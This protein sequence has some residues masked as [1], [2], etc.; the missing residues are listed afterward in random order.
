MS[1][2]LREHAPI[3]EAGWAL[4]DDEA[5]ERLDARARRPQ[6]RR[7]RRPARLGA[8]G[9]E[10]RSHADSRRQRPPTASTAAQR[11]VLPLVELRAPFTVARAELRDADRGA[12]DVDLDALDEAAHRIAVAENARRLPRLGSGRRS[13]ASLEASSQRGDHARRRLRALSRATSPRRSRRCSRPAS[14][15]PTGWRSGPTPTPACS[16]PASTAA[17]RCS[18]TCA[19]SSAGRSSGRPAST[20]PSCSACAAATS[21]SSPARTSRSATTDHDAD[22]V[23]LYLR[24]ELQLP[25]R[26]ARGRRRASLVIPRGCRAGRG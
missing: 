22:A 26:H 9:D 24:G 16:R 1:H 21:C 2:L 18:T 23:Q 11:R 14:T 7:L 12:E 15:A 8:L 20:A 19:R 10:P 5:R 6:A 3:T 4:I 17:T 25:R 13:A